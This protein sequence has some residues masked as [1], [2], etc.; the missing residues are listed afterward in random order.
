MSKKGLSAAEKR[1]R[2]EALFHETKDFFQLKELEKIA[3]KR[4]GIVVQSV[5][6]VLQELVNDNL[7]V[8]DKIGLSNYFW[9]FPS[10]A[11]QSRTTKIEELTEELKKLK[12]KNVELQSSI[13]KASG[14]REESDNRKTLLKN[15]SELETK[16]INYKKELD[17]YKEHDPILLEAK[18]LHAEVA[19]ESANRWT[20][21]IFIIQSY[22]SSKFGI[23]RGDFNKQFDIPEDLDTL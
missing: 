6:D 2:L 19:L 21:N 3:P 13:E 9:S 4:K 14:G 1:K 8:Q 20:D 16:R 12:D 7:V 18:K 22:C 10:S 17:H 23:E 15:L 5:K 11:L